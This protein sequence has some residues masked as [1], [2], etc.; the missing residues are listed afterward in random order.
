MSR[1]LPARGRIGVVPG[2]V[3][4][5]LVLFARLVA[6]APM[7]AADGADAVARAALQTICHHGPDGGAGDHGPVP[8]GPHEGCVLCPACHLLAH[9]AVPVPG[10]LVV[11]PR[12]LLVGAV[13]ALPPATGPPPGRFRPVPAPTGPPFSV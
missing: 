3:L 1:P 13:A 4:A 11:P 5:V 10:G 9:A 7:P 12:R 6:A 8:A 2:M